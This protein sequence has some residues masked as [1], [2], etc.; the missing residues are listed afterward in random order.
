M[1]FWPVVKEIPF[2]AIFI[3]SSLFAIF[4]AVMK[5]LSNFPR[6][7]HEEHF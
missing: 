1:I 4:S 5:G 6:E 3:L 2:K 7:H